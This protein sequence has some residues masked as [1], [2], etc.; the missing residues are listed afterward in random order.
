M[1]SQ[2]ATSGRGEKVERRSERRGSR[3]LLRNDP[4]T[5]SFLPPHA[6]CR[7]YVMAFWAC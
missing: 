3:A 5:L 1:I 7:T 4:A 2:P 6:A